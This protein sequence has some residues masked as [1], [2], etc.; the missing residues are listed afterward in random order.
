MV[1][2]I[3]AVISSRILIMCVQF[4]IFGGLKRD[5][6]ESA[7]QTQQTAVYSSLDASATIVHAMPPSTVLP[8]P[9]P[10][11][12]RGI[13]VQI[14]AVLKSSRAPHGDLCSIVRGA[15]GTTSSGEKRHLF[16]C[17]LQCVQKE[18]S[19]QRTNRFVYTKSDPTSFLKQRTMQL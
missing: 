5:N 12:P 13:F 6:W 17:Q 14:R 10:R 3:Y 18:Q 8:S 16:M 7:G 1:I 15:G 4:F 9:H 2:S 11:T 19:V